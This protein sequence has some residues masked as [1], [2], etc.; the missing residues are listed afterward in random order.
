MNISTLL[1]AI[2]ID[3]LY[4]CHP[5]LFFHAMVQKQVEFVEKSLTHC[6]CI[7]KQVIVFVCLFA[8]FA[9]AYSQQPSSA[10]TAYAVEKTTWEGF[11]RSDFVY[12]DRSAIVVAP[13]KAAIGRPWIWRPAFFGA[14]PSVDKALL[15]KGFHV[16]YYDL[17][18]L[19]GS[20]RSVKLG[21]EFYAA[22]L[23]SYRLSPK[24]TLEGFSRGGLFAFNWVAQ[25]ADKVACI[26][27]DAPVCNVFSWPGKKNKELWSGLLKEWNLTD[28]QMDAFPGNAIDQLAPLVK[29]GIP[30]ISVC[31]DSDRTVP[32]EENMKPVR[33]RYQELGGMVELILKPGVDHHPH[34]LEQPEPVVDF[35]LRYQAGYADCQSIH[36]WGSLA[37]SYQKFVK[38]RKGCIAFLGGSITEMR[39]WRN[40]IQEDLKQRFPYTEFTFIDAGIGST[41]STPHAFRLEND[42][43]S[44]ATPDLL[45]VEAAVNDDTN[46]FDYVAQTRGMEGIVRH[47]LATNPTMDIVMLHFIYDPFIRLLQEGQQPDVILNH[48]RVA[49]HYR[50]PSINLAQ[51]VAARMAA[52]EFDWNQFGGTH[53]HWFGHKFY[54]ASIN[55]LFD[56]QWTGKVI[57][58]TI[59][60][61][62]LPALPLDTYCYD[63]GH[64]VDIRQA[65]KLKGWEVVTD[66]SPKMEKVET[67]DGFV[68]VPMLEAQRAAATLSLDFTGR[69]IGLFCVAG[70]KA[71]V[72]EYSVDGAPFKTVDT[73]TQWSKGLYLPWV[74]ML[75]TELENK[76]HKLVLRVAKGER[77]ECQI[78]NFV[79]N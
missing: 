70:P 10:T 60:S 69:A 12:N 1:H 20:P 7:K 8:L 45:F 74:Y 48:E 76:P 46:R 43:L 63:K 19:Y 36:N 26:Y 34:S 16:V 27:V 47:A 77:T 73:Y 65:K 23:E 11:E 35:I 67:R 25:N 64:F 22:M 66:W 39:G 49:N 68:H 75:E 72:L 13:Q 53:P 18:H 30:I 61:H 38:E 41:G 78:R 4:F 62:S 71:A 32:Y 50:I 55:R 9:S 29:A 56:G 2:F 44:K 14:F 28:E 3:F 5:I 79:V 42:V 40:M 15:E 52:G 54:A 58:S 24:V 57:H 37:N 17:T 59:Q 31:G 51:E 6:L 33:D 21:N